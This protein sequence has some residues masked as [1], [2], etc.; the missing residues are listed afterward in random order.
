[1]H[2]EWLRPDRR[3]RA[4][5]RVAQP[6]GRGLADIDAG[7]VRGQHAADLVQQIALALGL[8]Q[9]LEFLVGIEMI[10]DGPLGGAGDEHQLART[11]QQR[12]LHCVLDQRLVHHRQHFLGAGLGGGQKSGAAS[13]DR[14]YS[15][16]NNRL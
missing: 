5:H 11:G 10:L 7:G 14:E 3:L 13:R 4:Q 9:M 15:S 1:M 8:Q 16:P 6:Q 2:E 12:L